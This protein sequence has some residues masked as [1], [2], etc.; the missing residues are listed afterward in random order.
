MIVLF[1]VTV[2]NYSDKQFEEE[3]VL[4]WYIMVHNSDGRS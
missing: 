3:R 4:F 1:P 2:V